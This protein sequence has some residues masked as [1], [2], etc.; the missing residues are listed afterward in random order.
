MSCQNVRDFLVDETAPRPAD[1]DAHLSTCLECRAVKAGH[2]RALS[3]R[4]ATL[5]SRTAE[6]AAVRRQVSAV[7]AVALALSAL[8]GLVW[9]EWPTPAVE[10]PL[11]VLATPEFAPVTVEVST[12]ADDE[13]AAAQRATLRVLTASARAPLD[14]TPLT[15]DATY[16]SFGRLPLWLAPATTRPLHSLGRAVSPL[17]RRSEE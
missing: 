5:P 1:L 16:A 17:V 9:L 13:Q 6:L 10:A 2:L 4:G 7:G 3:L 14:T 8:G 15:R 11:T 12:D